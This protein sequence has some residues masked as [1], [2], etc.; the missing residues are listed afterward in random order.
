MITLPPPP[1]T[2]V[3]EQIVYTK[4]MSIPD[5]ASTYDF[6]KE[7]IATAVIPSIKNKITSLLM[8]EDNWDGY[9]A[10]RL[11][12]RV[13]KNANRFIDAA[14]YIGHYPSTDDDVTLTPY[15]SVVIDYTSDAG[16]VSVEIGLNKIGYF[17]DFKNKKNHYSN[18]MAAS[19]R[20]VPKKIKVAFSSL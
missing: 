2:N 3:I 8:L 13:A 1:P 5:Y 11:D 9:G 16:L 6:L 15:G 4:P 14:S 20:I 12:E 17:T 10:S 19:F 7:Q 18:G